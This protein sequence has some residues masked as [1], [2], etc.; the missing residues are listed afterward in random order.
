MKRELRD[1][2][3]VDGERLG[4]VDI[5]CA[6]PA[7]LAK[8][9]AN[10]HNG[11]KEGD[12]DTAGYGAKKAPVQQGGQDK[13]EQSKGKY[14]SSFGCDFGGNADNGDIALLA[15]LVQTGTFY[16]HMQEQLRGGGINR[17]EIKR[18]FLSDVIAKKGQYPSAVEAGSPHLNWLGNE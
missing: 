2:L 8:L 4:C 18:K 10:N 5:S 3:H 9:I 17:D 14:D 15:S 6:Q 11:D 1:V 7:L 12:G 16:E 13:G